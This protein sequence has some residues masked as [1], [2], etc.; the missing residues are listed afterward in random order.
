METIKEKNAWLKLKQF[1]AKNGHLYSD[2]SK[3]YIYENFISFI[4]SKMAPDILMQIYY[5]TGIQPHGGA[6]YNAHINKVKELFGLD[7]NIL[8]VASG[9]IP[10]FATEVASIQ[11]KIG[12]GTITLYDPLLLHTNPKYPNMTLH[13]EKFSDEMSIKQFDL[14]TGIFPCEATESII[15]SACKEQKDFYVAMCGCIHFEHVPSFMRYSRYN[16][17]GFVI[18]LTKRL[19]EK[20]DNGELVIDYLPNDF[21]IDYPIL[22]NRKK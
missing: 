19:L 3:Q 20:H 21:G 11:R 22:Y 9:S 1:M 15:M 17:Q 5:D 14:V 12:K 6:F 13:N 4:E 18:E 7:R 8:D 2:T 16:Y 10:A